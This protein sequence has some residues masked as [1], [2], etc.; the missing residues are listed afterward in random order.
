MYVPNQSINADSPTCHV[1]TSEVI[2]TSSRVCSSPPAS[3]GVVL[4]NISNRTL[5]FT[6]SLL[7]NFNQHCYYY[8][9]CTQ[10]LIC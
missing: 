8:Y 4:D 5:K 3:D 7:N 1:Q 6:F 10:N 9:V 2:G